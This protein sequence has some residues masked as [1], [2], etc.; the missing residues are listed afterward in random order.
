MA[1]K[2]Q[3]GKGKPTASLQ[4][5]YICF[6]NS[7]LLIPNSSLFMSLADMEKKLKAYASH[8]SVSSP[9]FFFHLGLS[10]FT[11]FPE[12]DLKLHSNPVFFNMRSM[13]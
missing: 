7:C 12:K 11:W 6:K 10:S 1:A 3:K 8:V 2:I 13:P 5:N 9:V 4:S